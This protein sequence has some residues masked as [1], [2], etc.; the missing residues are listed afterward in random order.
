VRSRQRQKPK[1]Y[2]PSQQ[3]VSSEKYRKPRQLNP[4]LEEFFTVLKVAFVCHFHAAFKNAVVPRAT[5]M[6]VGRAVNHPQV[7][8]THKFNFS[9]KQLNGLA[10]FLLWFA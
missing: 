5:S 9:S 8:E 4:R 10:R 3:S 6:N 7:T 1:R 2:S